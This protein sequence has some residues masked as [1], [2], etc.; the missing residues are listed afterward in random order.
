MLYLVNKDLRK[1]YNPVMNVKPPKSLLEL[2]KNLENQLYESRKKI[3]KRIISSH[4]NLSG[5]N[6][7]LFCVFY[8]KASKKLI[9]DL[10]EN[11]TNT[12]D[13]ES[14]RALIIPSFF[15]FKHTL[16]LLT[17]FVVITIE[18][19]NQKD[20]NVYKILKEL[21]VA[22]FQKKINWEKVSLAFNIKV[23]VSK[24]IGKKMIEDLKNL[25]EKYVFNI[26]F[27][28]ANYIVVDNSNELYRYPTTNQVQ[29]EVDPISLFEAEAKDIRMIKED[30]EVL[31]RIFKLSVVLFSESKLFY[32]N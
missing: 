27:N 11:Q 31:E 9:N 21:N 4:D 7:Y 10:P 8:L 17:K 2:T 32:N 12:Y 14:D 1:V 25:A 19:K 5:D 20:H 22:K 13:F 16:E 26:G 30:I 24:A 28:N 18:G 23:H 29:F 15:L 6:W 3:A